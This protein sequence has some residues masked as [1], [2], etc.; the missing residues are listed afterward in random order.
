MKNYK[1]LYFWIAAFIAATSVV[2]CS[3]DVDLPDTGTEIEKDDIVNNIRVFLPTRAGQSDVNAEITPADSLDALLQQT[4]FPDGSIIYISQM[5]S[6]VSPAFP[7]THNENTPNLYAYQYDGNKDAT[8]EEGF[9]FTLAPNSA[10]IEWPVI[11]SYGS[12]GNTFGLYALYFPSGSIGLNV[13]ANYP[14]VYTVSEWENNKTIE[15][16]KNLDVMGAYHAFSSLYDRLRFRF[17]HLMVYV[18]LTLYVP[19]YDPNDGKTGTGFDANAFTA[20][21][22]QTANNVRNFI[23]GAF[24]GTSSQ[25]SS[26]SQPYMNLSRYW[27]IDYSA[28]RSSDKEGPLVYTIPITDKT[29]GSP[30][31][32]I[33]MHVHGLGR[34]PDASFE[35]MTLT[36]VRDFYPAS[37][38][39]TD[40]VRK[41]EFSAIFPPQT[42]SGELLYF[43]LKEVG[44]PASM[45]P[46]NL[47]ES[48][49]RR[50]YFGVN[51]LVT[52]KNEISFTSGT[53]NHIE[54]YIPRTGT[55]AILISAKVK[56]WTEAFTDMTVVDEAELN[57]NSAK[58]A[59]RGR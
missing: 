30:N 21:R 20:C 35:E 13:N 6:T 46:E 31:A 50:F 2:S 25:H 33:C 19:V 22:F 39:E 29:Y 40:R 14:N 54:L 12:V 34:S 27:R 4:E 9:N 28:N 45:L 48:S 18:R 47:N 3:E 23:P 17:F 38:I 36:N 5:G 49:I 41:Y 1:F 7:L 42:L 37:P 59:K 57:N 11:Q 10:P 51:Q 26:N 43:H 53:M 24:L 56:P 16:M 32:N 15:D 55:N 52:D 8:W 58:Q 44:T